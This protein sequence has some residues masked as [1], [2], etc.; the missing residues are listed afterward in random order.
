MQACPAFDRS[1]RPFE[2]QEKGP[3]MLGMGV[4]ELLIVI[5]FFLAPLIVFVL[6]AV[7]LVYGIKALRRYLRSTD[8]GERA[9]E[10]RKTLGETLRER[11]IACGMTQELVAESL[12]VS[13]QAV[14]KWEG[15][16]TDPS[17][18][19]LLALAELYGI[20]VEELLRGCAAP[21]RP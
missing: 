3:T 21:K 11:R 12:G 2:A 5:P 13:R 17:T 16:K 19:N 8:G 7:L 14:S 18:A 4:P 1:L 9:Q 15:G 6:V 20:P 10:V